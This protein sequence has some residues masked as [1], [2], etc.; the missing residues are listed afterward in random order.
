M[1]YLRRLLA[2]VTSASCLSATTRGGEAPE[3]QAFQLPKAGELRLHRVRPVDASV[4]ATLNAAEAT[5]ITLI[6][7][8][9]S[10]SWDPVRVE[11]D[12]NHPLVVKFKAGPLLQFTPSDKSLPIIWLSLEPGQNRALLQDRPT[13]GLALYSLPAGKTVDLGWLGR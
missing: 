5:A 10:Q 9:R 3:W 4:P 1:A 11:V 2:L 6:E 7:W 8:T 12:E 13:S